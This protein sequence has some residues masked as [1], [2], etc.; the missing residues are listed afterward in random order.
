VATRY[1]WD[2]FRKHLRQRE[3]HIVLRK[4]WSGRDDSDYAGLHDILGNA[5]LMTLVI[6]AV[7][8]KSDT[9]SIGAA[10]AVAAIAFVFLIVLLT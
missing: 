2:R 8:T 7:V 9:I 4:R 10:L 5:V 6:L 3:W 1:D